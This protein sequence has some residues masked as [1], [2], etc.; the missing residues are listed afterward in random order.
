M[1][2]SACVSVHVPPRHCTCSSRETGNPTR[3][4][5]L[6]RNTYGRLAIVQPWPYFVAAGPGARPLAWCSGM[7]SADPEWG[8][9]TGLLPADG[10]LLLCCCDVG[11]WG[12]RARLRRFYA[13][14]VCVI[15]GGMHRCKL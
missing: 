13:A 4:H 8:T 9:G 15:R 7:Q 1:H 10:E 6:P 2:V 3:P 11:G 14:D 5:P 12:T